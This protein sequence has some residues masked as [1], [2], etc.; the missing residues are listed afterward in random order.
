[1]T[2]DG[3]FSLYLL[4]VGCTVSQFR[5]CNNNGILIFAVAIAQFWGQRTYPR[6]NSRTYKHGV[7]LL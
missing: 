5:F 2:N 6:W 7:P 3:I 4:T 1:M